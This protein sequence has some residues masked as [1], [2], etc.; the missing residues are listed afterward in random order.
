MKLLSFLCLI[1]S[2]YSCANE[3]E[4]DIEKTYCN[5]ES[6]IFTGTGDCPSAPRIDSNDVFI[7]EGNGKH[8]TVLLIVPGGPRVTLIPKSFNFYEQLLHVAYVH[9][10]QTKQGFDQNDYNIPDAWAGADVDISKAAAILNDAVR[11]FKNQN[12]KIIILGVSWGAF[13][14]QQ[15]LHEYENNVDE[16]F[17]ATGRLNAKNLTEGSYPAYNKETAEYINSQV[18][19]NYEELLEGKNLSNVSYITAKYDQHTGK[20]S[21]EEKAWLAEHDIPLYELDGWHFSISEKEGTLL[22]LDL[23]FRK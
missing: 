9:Q 13:V 4:L 6:Y 15:W 5:P 22:L 3:P 14:T 2:L 21:N 8:D 7:L 1:L 16:L 18:N 11:H 12:K 23:I 20:L 17:I 19:K 10:P